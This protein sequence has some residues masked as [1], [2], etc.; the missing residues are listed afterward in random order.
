MGDFF[1]P[2]RSREMGSN[3]S[4][5]LPKWVPRLLNLVSS[6]WCTKKGQINGLF[7]W[8]FSILET[9][10]DP[11]KKKNRRRRGW[12]SQNIPGLFFFDF[13]IF[14]PKKDRSL[15][16]EKTWQPT[17]FGGKLSF[18][19]VC[20]I[21]VPSRRL[22]PTRR[23]DRLP[24]RTVVSGDRI[25]PPLKKAMEFETL[26]EGVPKISI[27][28]GQKRS[29]WLV[30]TYVRSRPGSPSSMVLRRNRRMAWGI[31]CLFNVLLILMEAPPWCHI[32]ESFAMAPR[33]MWL[34][35]D[36]F[37]ML[38]SE[39]FVCFTILYM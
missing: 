4:F 27:L 22:P 23:M 37:L 31:C 21:I 3:L 39:G 9:F 13:S 34:E 35:Y 2:L 10:F 36:D 8:H 38:R 14:Q 5:R 25:T 6:M 28:R 16:E 18:Q 15:L 11:I 30:T 17:N 1:L 33:I 24:G 19:T 12:F 32:L 7:W 29:P 20:W 26:L